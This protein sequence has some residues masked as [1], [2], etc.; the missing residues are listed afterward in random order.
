MGKPLFQNQYK[1]VGRVIGV[2]GF[3]LDSR[4]AADDRMVSNSLLLGGKS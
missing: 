1:A 4:W 3:N 2:M